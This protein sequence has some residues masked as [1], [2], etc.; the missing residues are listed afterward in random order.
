LEKKKGKYRLRDY[1]ERGAD[2]NLGLPT[3]GGDAVPVIDVLHRTLWLMENQP[4]RLL[5]FLREGRPNREQLRL[6]AQALAGPALK[7]GELADVSPTA[8]LSALAKLMANWRSLIEDAAMTS[9]Q[10]DER[11]TGQK[12]L[13]FAKESRR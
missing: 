4:T 5:E 10:R 7:G 2:D 1:R 9:V 6:V 13:D 11:K 8:E 12:P 3:A